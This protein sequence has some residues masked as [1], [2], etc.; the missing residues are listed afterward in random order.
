MQWFEMQCLCAAGGPAAEVLCRG[1]GALRAQR[2]CGPGLK[3][4]QRAAGRATR[5]AHAAASQPLRFPQCGRM[6][7]AWV[8]VTMPGRQAAMLQVVVDAM[9]PVMLDIEGCQEPTAWRTRCVA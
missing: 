7:T 6:H 1:A 5:A 3:A 2:L 4:R 8:S 9:S